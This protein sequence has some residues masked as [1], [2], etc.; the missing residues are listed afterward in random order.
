MKRLLLLSVL[1]CTAAAFAESRPRMLLNYGEGILQTASTPGSYMGA[2]GSFWNPAG[3]ATMSRSEAVFTWNDRNEARK[4]LDNWGLLVGGHGIG[5]SMHRTLIPTGED[6]MRIDDYQ[7]ALAGGSRADNWGVSYGWSKGLGAGDLRQHYVTVGNIVRPYKYISVG[8]TGTLGLRNGRTQGQADLGLRPFNGSHRVTLFGDIAAHDKDNPTTM[9]WGAGLEVMPLD[10]I[11]I[12]GKISKL[13]PD[14]PA[15]WFTVGVGFTLDATSLHVIP[16]YD[17]D[18]ER[19][20]TS[21]AIRVGRVEPSIQAKKLIEKDQRI[22]ALG[23]RGALTYRKAKWLESDRHSLYEML[24]LVDEAKA[25][26]S[27]GGIALNLSGFSST[28]ELAWELTEKLKEFRADG[29][30]VYMFVDRPGM[31]Q[32]YLMTQADYVWMDPLG[33]IDMFGWVMGRTY[34]KGMFEKLGLGVEE[35][36]YFEY[37][38]A[39]ESYARKDMSEKDREQRQTLLDAFHAEWKRAITENMGIS[40]DS[41][42][43]ALDSLGI[44]TAHEA[45][46]FGFVDTLGRWDDAEELIEFAR[47]SKSS[48]IEREDLA[49]D[50][51]SDP[52]WGEYP[53]VAVVYAL[54][55]CAMDTGIRARYTS[56]LLKRLAEDEDI[57]AVVL[58]VDSPGGDGMASDWVADGMREVSKEKPMVVSQGRLA[59]SG[60]YWLSSPGDRVFTSPFTITGSIGVI[61]GWV[62]NEGLTDKT[63]LTYDKVQVGRHADLGSGVTLP[64]LNLE[65]PNRTVTEEERVRIEKM[66]RGHYDDFV[67]RVAEDRALPREDVEKVAQGRVWAGQAA[68][69]RNLVDEIGGLEQSIAYAKQ[70]AGFS[71]KEKVQVIEYPKQEWINFDRLFGQAS[72]MSIIASRLGLL[73]K[74]AQPVEAEMDYSLHVIE[75][76]AKFR[77]TP[78][79]M[80]PPEDMFDE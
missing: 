39:F 78:L 51:Q 13:H 74:Q 17:K 6:F 70:S 76:Y 18:S 28:L 14:E 59:A 47:G 42:E 36:R 8:C 75:Q 79:F 71:K 27:I 53:R 46:R 58:R 40:S 60:G 73:S 64:I 62:W 48:F 11:R 69:D 15:S 33:D 3:W 77:G 25:D 63:G 41:I 12:A 21:Y 43:L 34:H 56:R 45:E 24:Q 61:A 31:V 49:E 72:P 30:E 37:K 4:R 16:H 5:A 50:D 52:Y 1:F 19:Q 20:F 68:I 57:E 9:Q 2:L 22:V 23:M 44:V 65:V 7:L 55:E 10:G 66:I 32:T 35:W 80:L 26:R 67:G 54:G 38:S 29:K